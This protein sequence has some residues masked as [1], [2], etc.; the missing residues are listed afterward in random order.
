MATLLASSSSSFGHD[1]VAVKFAFE[2][3]SFAALMKSP[4]ECSTRKT[5]NAAIVFVVFLIWRG[6]FFA[7]KTKFQIKGII[8]IVIAVCIVWIVFAV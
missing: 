8:W 2:I 7:N 4:K 6:F 1:T 3:L 5:N